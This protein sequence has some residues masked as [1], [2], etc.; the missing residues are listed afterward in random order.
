MLAIREQHQE[1]HWQSRLNG[2]PLAGIA[3]SDYLLEKIKSRQAKVAIIGLGYVG[4]PLAMAFA[5]AAP[6][7]QA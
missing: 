3:A 4:L 7:S 6:L 2:R 5:S 1:Q